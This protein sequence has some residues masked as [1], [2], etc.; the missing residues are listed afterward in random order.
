MKRLYLTAVIS[1]VLS[2][3][4]MAAGTEYN[5]QISLILDGR[6]SDYSQNTAA[7]ALPG[8]QLGD[9]AGLN[10]AGF[11]IG[12]SE[13]TLSSN[14]DQDFSGQATIAFADG[15][16]SVE[17]AYVQTLAIGNGI[18]VKFGRFLSAFG[19]LNKHHAHA[20]D[21]ADAPL[22]YRALFGAT[23]KDDGVQLN[24]ILPADLLMQVSAEVLSGNAFPA[25]GNINGGIGASVLHF[26]LGDDIGVSQSWQLGLSH[27]QANNILERTDASANT[28]SGRSRIN[29]LDAVYK[30]APDGNRLERNFRMQMEV[31]QRSEDGTI[32]DSVSSNTSSYTGDQ[33]GWYAQAVYQFVRGWSAGVRRDRLSARNSGNDVAVLNDT[34]I[35]SNGYDPKRS[36]VM[37][38]WQSSEFSRIRLQFNN[39]KSVANV[40]DKQMF[41]QYTFSLG[42]HGAHSF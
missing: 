29:A 24:Y 2:P 31:F 22:M 12:E 23:L 13:I 34:G 6:Y 36:S 20:W 5:P 32:S 9:E 25:A 38:Q 28:F 1:L 35:N 17:E 4:T 41:V 18:T 8:F 30:W 3:P 27:W 21:F 39:D 26:T 19:Y 33:S 40:S 15:E 42:A 16:S 11:A 37:L 10:P 7:Y 14:I